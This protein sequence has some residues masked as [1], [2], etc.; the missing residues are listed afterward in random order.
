MTLLDV[1]VCFGTLVMDA[2]H[3]NK[4]T[5]HRLSHDSLELLGHGGREQ[6]CLTLLDGR[7]EGDDPSD[8]RTEAHLQQLV[9][10]RREKRDGELLDIIHIGKTRIRTEPLK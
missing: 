4:V 10:W 5:L 9:G 8:I 7:E 1:D 3:R 2:I 6:Q